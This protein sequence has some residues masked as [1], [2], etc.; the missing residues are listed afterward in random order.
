MKTLTF[1]RHGRTN[2]NLKKVMSGHTNAQLSE[3]GRAELLELKKVMNY[4]KVEILFSSDLS[5]AID[6][7]KIIY[8]EMVPILL[9]ELREIYFGYY[10]EKPVAEVVDFFYSAFLKNESF[11]GSE[12]YDVVKARAIKALDLILEFMNQN[13]QS[14]AAIFS[15]NA[16]M[17]MIYHIYK[18]TPKEEYRQQSTE[19]GHG[20]SLVFDDDDH[21]VD[22]VELVKTI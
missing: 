18:Q 10:E 13:N 4:P 7:A 12:T 14:T 17:R 9:K 21:F 1:I 19:N 15:H 16:F 20:F 2:A 6:S 3:Q 11:D 22:M 8:P 5:R